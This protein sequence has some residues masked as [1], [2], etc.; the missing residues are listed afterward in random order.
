MNLE[1]YKETVARE[2]VDGEILSELDD[3][4]LE[5]DLG[6]SSKIHRLRLMQIITGSHSA[7]DFLTCVLSSECKY[8]LFS[9]FRNVLLLLFSIGADS[10]FSFWTGLSNERSFCATC[11]RVDRMSFGW[12]IEGKCAFT[13]E[14][15][16]SSFCCDL[17]VLVIGG[18]NGNGIR[19]AMED[20][21]STPTISLPF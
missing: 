17:P 3:K 15:F 14:C 18:G 8:C 5:N 9:C 4:S 20:S 16:S 6:I 10:W 11:S 1:Q 19:T 21:S 2:F 12:C 7:K 13:D